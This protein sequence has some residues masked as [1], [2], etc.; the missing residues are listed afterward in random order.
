MEELDG[1]VIPLGDAVAERHADRH[2]QIGLHNEVRAHAVAQN[3]QRVH[4]AFLREDL[5]AEDLKPALLG[6]FHHG[7]VFFRQT[8]ADRA[9]PFGLL[10][11]LIHELFAQERLLVLHQLGD[12]L[13]DVQDLLLGL[14][15][16]GGLPVKF[17][18]GLIAR[19]LGRSGDA[20]AGVCTQIDVGVELVVIDIREDPLPLPDRAAARVEAQQDLLFKNGGEVDLDLADRSRKAD[21]Q[22]HAHAPAAAVKMLQDLARCDLGRNV[23]ACDVHMVGRHQA[24]IAADRRAVRIGDA[25]RLHIRRQIVAQLLEALGLHGQLRQILRRFLH[26]A[27]FDRLRLHVL[28]DRVDLLL[29]ELDLLIAGAVEIH[30]RQNVRLAR[31]GVCNDI[32]AVLL[33]DRVDPAVAG[34]F[35]VAEIA[36]VEREEIPRIDR[37]LRAE[38]HFDI[39]IVGKVHRGLGYGDAAARRDR[40]LHLNGQ[41][42][43][44]KEDVLSVR[45]PISIGIARRSG[46]LHIHDRAVVIC[47]IRALVRA[48]ALIDRDRVAHRKAAAGISKAAGLLHLLNRLGLALCILIQR[49]AEQAIQA[50]GHAGHVAFGEV[51]HA[52]VQLQ[53]F[54][55]RLLGDD[56]QHTH[57]L[58]LACKRRRGILRQLH[59][60]R[61]ALFQSRRD[62]AAGDRIVRKCGIIRRHIDK[63]LNAA[64]HIVA[65]LEGI[66]RDLF[67]LELDRHIV[68]RLI[69][70]L[71]RHLAHLGIQRHIFRDRAAC[72]DRLGHIG[73]EIP[74]EEHPAAAVRRLHSADPRAGGIHPLA[75]QCDA[76]RGDAIAQLGLD[77]IVFRGRP[78]RIAGIAAG[79]GLFDLF[80][81]RG[82][83]RGVD[84]HARGGNAGLGIP[85]IHA[86]IHAHA[87]RG[88]LRAA[89][90]ALGVKAPA[91]A[92]QQ[93][94]FPQRQ[95][96]LTRP[97]RDRIQVAGQGI[98]IRA[99]VYRHAELRE[100][101]DEEHR[102]L[103]AGD[104]A[105]RREFPTTDTG[106]DT[107]FCRPLHIRRVPRVRRH[108][109]ELRRVRVA[110]GVYARH[111]AEHR[112]EHPA[113]HRALR[114]K[115][116]LAHAAEEAVHTGILHRVKIPVRCLHVGKRIADLRTFGCRLRGQRAHGQHRQQHADDQQNAEKPFCHGSFPPGSVLL[117]ALSGNR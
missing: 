100:V 95:N 10:A 93:P 1:E 31:G 73:I 49:G 6:V 53:V 79:G 43:R 3:V 30:R 2:V 60:V 117:C 5:L 32:A 92:R 104:E 25:V 12:L 102:H 27:A 71:C 101:A 52:A 9:G 111:A 33:A 35:S 62:H 86:L 76:V 24:H 17:I 38:A 113:R 21:R 26:K 98:I 66:S 41:N 115:A 54:Y 84:A 69:Q 87:Q 99:G 23:L 59:A 81:L 37:R 96:G 75:E 39:F 67:R 116:I 47:I 7:R 90:A 80:R 63:R 29:R 78:A 72:A 105:L 20:D 88:R 18:V 16:G 40:R 77:L 103:L 46:D 82:L 45:R 11:V 34:A 55:L 110:C 57:A 107:I 13:A 85:R 106:G 89:G 19:G 91:G 64:A 74:A 70:S 114:R 65:D 97:G 4:A 22:L 56:I 109:G 48:R 112:D 42:V 50:L 94:R 28:F 61:P 14:G 83:V 68:R 36:D 15:A 58:R 51:L 44:R 8:A 108:V